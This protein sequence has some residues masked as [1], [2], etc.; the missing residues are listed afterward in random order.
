MSLLTW[1]FGPREEK[2]WELMREAAV[3]IDNQAKFIEKQ[4]KVIGFLMA[5][6]ESLIKEIDTLH[7]IHQN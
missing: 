7:T 2:D 4:D 1:I 3:L 5:Q 6:N